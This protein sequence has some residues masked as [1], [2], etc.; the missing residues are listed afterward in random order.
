MKLDLI[1]YDRAEVVLE[2]DEGKTKRIKCKIINGNSF[3]IPLKYAGH[4]IQSITAI[5]DNKYA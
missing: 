5:K 3:R 1:K 2:N 4:K